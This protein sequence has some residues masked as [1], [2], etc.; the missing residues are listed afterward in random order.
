[1]SSRKNECIIYFALFLEGT[2][3]AEPVSLA[4]ARI[5]GG[6]I[7][8]RPSLR[9][10]GEGGRGSRGE[11]KPLGGGFARN[12]PARV[13]IEARRIAAQPGSFSPPTLSRNAPLPRS[14]R[15]RTAY[16]RP[17]FAGRSVVPGSCSAGWFLGHHHSAAQVEPPAVRRE[18]EFNTGRG[19]VAAEFLDNLIEVAGDG[20]GGSADMQVNETS[21]PG[22]L[23]VR[24][25]QSRFPCLR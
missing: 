11:G 20:P 1:M 10:C 12:I 17:A 15:L 14:E 19:A 24:P 9:R 8:G 2:P 18:F 5:R 6:P 13:I 23:M 22:V 21:R 25:S 7:Q 16:R 4:A 3:S